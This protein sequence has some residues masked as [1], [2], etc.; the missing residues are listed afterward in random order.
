MVALS[1]VH[2]SAHEFISHFPEYEMWTIDTILAK[3][4]EVNYNYK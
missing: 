2:K 1:G 4:K 3:A